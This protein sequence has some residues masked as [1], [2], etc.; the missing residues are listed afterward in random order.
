MHSS[1]RISP[2]VETQKEVTLP[3]IHIIA[4][5]VV[6][7][8]S[9]CGA[10]RMDSEQAP[11]SL[12]AHSSRHLRATD[13]I[14]R[15]ANTEERSPNVDIMISDAARKV[16]EATWWK[17]KFALWKYLLQKNP[18]QAREDLGQGSVEV[19]LVVTHNL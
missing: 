15:D 8:A 5:L 4:L 9:I 12:T 7:M 16:K 10:T 3:R 6:A 11:A 18:M 14:P 1:V 17:V 2:A 19:R 13:D